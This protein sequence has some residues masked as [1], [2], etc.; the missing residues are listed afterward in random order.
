MPK[1]I[2]SK[3]F[4]LVL[5]IIVLMTLLSCTLTSSNDVDITS[6]ND[7]DIT[8][9]DTKT[10]SDTT[11]SKED[12]II[13]DGKYTVSFN[14]NGGT[15]INSIDVIEGSTIN[16][17]DEPTKKGYIFNY[18]EYNDE[19]YDFSNII[20]SDIELIAVWSSIFKTAI[21]NNEVTITGLNLESL[22]EVIIPDEIDGMPVKS[23][24]DN[25]FQDCSSLTSITIPNSV[26]SIGNNAFYGCSS[27]ESMTLPYIGSSQTS[28]TFL[29]YLFGSLNYRNNRYFVPSSLKEVVILDGCTS[30]P[31]NAF[32]DCSSLTS[33]II[34]DSVTSIGEYAFFGCSSLEY[35]ELNNI[36]YLG[37]NG[38]PYL[39]LVRAK[40]NEIINCSIPS[41]CKF[42]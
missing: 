7:V 20:N 30:I 34:P 5:S 18:W 4:S 23:I 22:Y 33:I 31:N 38:N 9:S 41:G 6:S 32:Q 13:S 11:T 2:A 26:T 29:G 1:T 15:N 21:T 40:N 10:Q 8:S 24:G 35:N 42:I 19:E 28:Y 27:L 17:P 14:T 36:Y 39:I 37:N 25:A 3:I 16:E 12:N